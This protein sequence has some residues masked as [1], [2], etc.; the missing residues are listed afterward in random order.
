M[1]NLAYDL[2]TLGSE[3]CIYRNPACGVELVRATS[4]RCT[5]RTRVFGLRA[6]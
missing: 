3:T 5:Q 4:L 2:S 1:G 6:D